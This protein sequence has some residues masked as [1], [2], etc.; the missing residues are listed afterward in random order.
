MARGNGINRLTDRA[1]RNWLRKRA[2]GDGPRML[3]D[4]G[5]LYLW[6]TPAGTPVWQKSYVYDGA[7]RTYSA[8]VYPA[9]GLAEARRERDRVEAWL[10]EGKNPVQQRRLE[11]A[12]NIDAA[13]KTFEI[14][15]PEWIEFERKRKRWS[16]VHYTKS[17]R[18]IERDVLPALGKHTIKDFEGRPELV[19]RA[20]KNI[21]RRGVGDTA[22]KIHQHVE[23][24]FEYAAAHGYIQG[25]NPA[26]PARKILPSGDNVRRRPALLSFPE[27]GDVLRKA[28]AANLSRAV[29]M[30]HRLLAFC[31]GARIANVVE[32]EWREF[33]LEAEPPLWTIPRAKMKSRRD[34]QHDHRIVLCARIAEELREWRNVTG[35]KGHLFRSPQGGAYISREALEKC[36]RVTMALRDKHS[37][38]GWRAA[39]S[40]LARDSEDPKFERDVVELA[41]DHLHDVE[42]VR[43]YDR[44]ERLQQRIRLAKWWG[45]QLVQAQRG[46]VV[47]QIRKTA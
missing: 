30:A 36:Y 4:G 34:R 29:Y 25:D 2:S 6:P 19:T 45:E 31:P 27:L 35:S 40:T 16:E 33:A 21:L 17:K 23:G 15:F 43:A 32:A 26:R 7:E 42:V 39:F 46:A 44:G 13:G 14:V 9:I 28:E 1:I 22:K 8:G 10:R 12:A 5:G 37:P 11:K 47:T 24:I 41:L 18:A 20:I 38:H 3:S